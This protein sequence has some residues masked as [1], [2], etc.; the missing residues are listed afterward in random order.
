MTVID[1]FINIFISYG[2]K[3]KRGAYGVR[4]FKNKEIDYNISYDTI[5]KRICIYNNDQDIEIKYSVK[6]VIDYLDINIKPLIRDK[7]ISKILKKLTKS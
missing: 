4:V 1:T 6:D 7:K 2:F 3:E 5:T